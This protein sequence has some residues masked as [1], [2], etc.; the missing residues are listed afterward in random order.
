ME[1]VREAPNRMRAFDIPRK[2]TPELLAEAES[3]LDRAEA[4]LAGAPEIYR[5]RVAFVRCG[6]EFTRLVVD[7]RRWM[8][9]V[10][11]SKGKDAEAIAKV[12][13]NWETAAKMKATFPPFAINWIA[14]FREGGDNKRVMGLHPDNPLSGRVKREAE[15]RCIE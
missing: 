10:E 13:A 15:T 6:L 8:Q 9:R 1:F 7:T 11:Q 12:K 4:R 5:R 14:V 2:Y 3:L